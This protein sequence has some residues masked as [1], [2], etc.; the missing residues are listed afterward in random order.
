MNTPTFQT[1]DAL[2]QI[3]DDD[4]DDGSSLLDLFH[5]LWFRRR[6]LF[7]TAL[8]IIA[9]GVINLYQ[10][11]PRYTAT[12]SMLIGIPKTKVVDIDEVLSA[13]TGNYDVTLSEMEVLRSRGLAGKL[14]EKLNLQSKEEFNPGL[15]TSTPGLLSRI[16][17]GE[18]IP[19]Q[20]KESLGFE[21]PESVAA[22]SEEE[23]ARKEVA[24]ATNILLDQLKVRRVSLSNVINISFE[25]TRPKM[26]ALI[27]NELPEV[28]IIGQMEA[29]L[30]ATEKATKWLN[31]QLTDLKEKVEKSE[32]AVETYR[33]Q[34]D[35]TEVQGESIL[36]SQL[37]EVNKRLNLAR[38]ERAEAE[39][40]L[41]HIKKLQNKDGSD[42]ESARE[43]MSSSVIQQ[44]RVQKLTE[45]KKATELAVRFKENHPNMQQAR[46][47]I[48]AIEEQIKLEIQRIVAGLKNEVEVAQSRE[49][50]LSKTLKDLGW[51]SGEQT[52]EAI[53]LRALEREAS[54]N[55]ALF[56]TF[57]NRFKETSSTVGMA[58]ANARVISKA[59]IPEVASYP[60]KRKKLIMIIAGAFFVAIMLVLLVQALHQGL[61]SPEQIEKE[62]GLAAIA[63]IPTVPDN[64]IP[65]DYILKKP[66]SS[67]GEALNSLKTSLILS[68]PDEA[69]KAIQITSSVPKEG[70]STLA[71]AFARFLAKSGNKVIL[72]D[73][74]LRR[75]SLEAKLGI[76][77]TSKGLTDLVMSSD[78]PIEEFMF[79]DEKSGAFIMP[80]GE[81]EYFNAANVFS[82]LRM[83]EVIDLLKKTFDYVIVD[84]PPV[85]SVSDSRIIGQLVDK[86]VFVVK[87]DKTPRKVVKAAVHLLKSDGV[88]IAGCVLQQV[89]LERYGAY[90]YGD[91]G[92]Y[93]HYGRN[94]DYYTN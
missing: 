34:H 21:P 85:M 84:A 66:H 81:A 86:T 71:I 44:L 58:E 65:H 37:L 82:S 94:G 17:P 92:Y 67:F 62:L 6:L 33:E 70:K 29:K 48:R 77:A 61:L 18:W 40:R 46:A 2:P 60:N 51:Q 28:Y 23:K 12:S 22:P 57:L 90:G 83:Q 93:Y 63:L 30:E 68:N 75:A 9:V 36:N 76:S 80:K 13:G 27:A 78:A 4:D 79:K 64:S 31:E 91:S 38:A 69:I 32:K 73:G 26:A 54:A 53:S 35:L 56:E 16:K 39:A 5:K 49:Y 45:S 24:T 19:D 10:I 72:V 41:R 89:N 11:V 3:V 52:K 87:W 42:I 8:F 20:L 1:G 7:S 74:D 50:S 59:E 55:R 88:D 15:R 43:V 14:V 25:S 47:K